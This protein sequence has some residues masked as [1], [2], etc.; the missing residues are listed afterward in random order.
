MQHLDGTRE[1]HV[2]DRRGR[3]EAEE[4]RPCGRRVEAEVRRHRNRAGGNLG[5]RI[6]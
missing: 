1:D 5:L 2:C 6:Y 4:L 3:E